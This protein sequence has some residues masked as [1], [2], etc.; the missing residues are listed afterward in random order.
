M[1]SKNIFSETATNRYALAL[2]ELANENSDLENVENQSKNILELLTQSMDFK[3]FVKDPTSN[4]NEQI[5]SIELI[6][7]KLLF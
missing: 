6:A 3:S 1:S 2:Y 7:G 4:K 5:K